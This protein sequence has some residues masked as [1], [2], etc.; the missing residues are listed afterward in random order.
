MNFFSWL[1]FQEQSELDDFNGDF[2]M[3]FEEAFL[4]EQG[5]TEKLIQDMNTAAG[6]P[7]YDESVYRCLQEAT[8]S[9]QDQDFH[10]P[11][12]ASFMV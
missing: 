3:A 11:N 1:R 9:N 7:I 10:S 8:G 12:Q 5:F 2:Q 4:A 6:N